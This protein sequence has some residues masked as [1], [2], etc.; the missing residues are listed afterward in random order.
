MYPEEDPSDDLTKKMHDYG[1]TV[2]VTVTELPKKTWISIDDRVEFDN[3]EDCQAYD[4]EQLFI[5]ERKRQKEQWLEEYHRRRDD[6]Y[7]KNDSDYD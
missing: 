5:D 3:A 4:N 1:W 7:W 2:K 6:P